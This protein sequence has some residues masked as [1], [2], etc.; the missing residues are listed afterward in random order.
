MDSAEET[1]KHIAE[2]QK[3]MCKAAQIIKHRGAY[4]DMSKLYS[5]EKDYLDLYGADLKTIVYGSPEYFENLEKVK[6]ALDHHYAIHSHHPQHYENGILGMSLIDLLEMIIDWYSS[7]HKHKNGNI[8]ESLR[9]N[10]ERFNIS[11]DLLQ[12]LQNTLVQLNL[13]E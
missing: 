12:I 13:E 10:Q 6:L 9:I 3:I 1:K 2:V 8:K 7:C 5:P 11:N 4:H